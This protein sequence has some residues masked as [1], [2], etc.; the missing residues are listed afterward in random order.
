MDQN[1]IIPIKIL[2]CLLHHI[3]IFVIIIKYIYIYILMLPGTTDSGGDI[4]LQIKDCKLGSIGFVAPNVRIKIV[5]VKTGKT[6]GANETGELHVKVPSVMNGYYKNP[7]ATKRA[8]D[9]DGMKLK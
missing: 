1:V 8:F 6:L 3:I 4:C 2:S 9:S 7:E 5:D